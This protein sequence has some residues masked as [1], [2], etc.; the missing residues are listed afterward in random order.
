MIFFNYYL[1]FERERRKIKT[2]LNIMEEKN[3]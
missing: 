2:E 1:F 3:G